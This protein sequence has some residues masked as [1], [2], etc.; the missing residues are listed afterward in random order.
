M[1]YQKLNDAI[2]KDHYPVPFIDQMRDRLRTR[3]PLFIRWLFQLQ[4]YL[5]CT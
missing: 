1:D 5:D 2:L 3:V 4:P